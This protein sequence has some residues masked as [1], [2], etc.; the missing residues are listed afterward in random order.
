MLVKK[1]QGE[2]STSKLRSLH[3]QIGN[4]KVKENPQKKE[5]LAGNPGASSTAL[6]RRLCVL[7]NGCRGIMSVRSLRWRG[8]RGGRDILIQCRGWGLRCRR[9]SLCIWR[10]GSQWD[11]LRIWC[12]GSWLNCL[13]IRDGGIWGNCVADGGGSADWTLIKHPRESSRRTIVSVIAGM[14]VSRLLSGWDFSAN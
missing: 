13:S 3:N 8:P 4:E 12:D 7:A 5:S 9:N 10:T 14:T 6:W 11:K 2:N 1:I